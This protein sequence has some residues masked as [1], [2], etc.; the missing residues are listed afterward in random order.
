MAEA[1]PSADTPHEVAAD[2]LRLHQEAV[3]AQHQ[4]SLELAVRQCLFTFTW[5]RNDDQSYA[6]CLQQLRDACDAALQRLP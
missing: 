4:A 2:V 3:Q 5:T 6:S 1:E